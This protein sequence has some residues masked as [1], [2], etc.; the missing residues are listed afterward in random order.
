MKPDSTDISP[1][2]Q[3]QSPQREDLA[4]FRTLP[5][6][7]R[8]AGRLA[9]LVAVLI[10]LGPVLYFG[11][12]GEIARWH[13]AAA[14]E[15]WQDG[16]KQEALARLEVA[17]RWAG[18]SAGIYLCRADWMLQERKFQES[19]DDYDK[20]L[21]LDSRNLWAMIQRTEVLQHL[22]KHAQAI[23]AWKTLV[24]R[25]QS[26]SAEQRAIFLNGLA[27]AQAVGDVELDQ[28]L[29][30]II[31]AINL[32]GQDA[33]MLDTRGFIHYRRDN[34]EAA[35][36]DLNLA[37]Q[38]MEQNHRAVEQDR[39]YIDRAEFEQKLMASRRSLAVIRYHRSLVFDSLG[40]TKEAEA[41]RRRVRQLGFDPAPSLF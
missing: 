37:V 9:I 31:Q 11:L 14:M 16:K 15:L 6:Q 30:N 36:A 10:T 17:F 3:T 12:P 38:S 4:T 26:A 13:Q 22:G 35:K 25:Y 20:S 29:E 2:D 39:T 27:Y 28:A 5:R 8:W 32:F 7:S 21:A 19:L 18:D 34:L 40:K 33:A 23:Q 1:D 41:D 24:T